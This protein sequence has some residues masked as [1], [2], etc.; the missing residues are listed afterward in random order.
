MLGS[1][2]FGKMGK[3]NPHPINLKEFLKFFTAVGMAKGGETLVTVIQHVQK[4]IPAWVKH[5]NFGLS[6]PVPEGT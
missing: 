3:G 2:F 6:L 4:G 1:N 5:A